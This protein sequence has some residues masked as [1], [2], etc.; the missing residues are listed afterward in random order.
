M[1]VNRIFCVLAAAAVVLGACNKNNSTNSGSGEAPEQKDSTGGVQPTAMLVTP[2]S[3]QLEVGKTLTLTVVFQPQDAKADVVWMSEDE[4]IATVKDGVVTAVKEGKVN[5]FASAGSLNAKSEIEVVAS[6]EVDEDLLKG[7]NYYIFH[8]SDEEV[9]ASI[10][11]KVVKNYSINGDYGDENANSVLEI[12]N[13]DEHMNE[14]GTST[15]TPNSWGH[16]GYGWM[17]LVSDPN[18]A[19]GNICGGIRQRGNAS[20]D[21]TGVTGDYTFVCIYKCPNSNKKGDGFHLTLYS[22][23]ATGG[24]HG[25]A[26]SANTEG[27]WTKVEVPMKTFFDKGVD[28]STVY[29][30]AVKE[31]FYTVGLVLDGTGQEIN[32][33]AIFVYKK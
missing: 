33:D 11:S 8:F 6:S 13:T 18:A 5:I 27:E 9:L 25:I 2:S 29:T 12:W 17:Q 30:T 15:D 26:V 3:A 19:W 31:A 32:V 21:L 24:E 23:N 14:G 20:V 4:K 28:W 22:T 10:Q 16:T 1:K 7:S